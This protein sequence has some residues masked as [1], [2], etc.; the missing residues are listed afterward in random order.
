MSYRLQHFNLQMIFLTLPLAQ[1]KCTKI[2]CLTMFLGFLS[3]KYGPCT[4]QVLSIFYS[5][6][7]HAAKETVSL[8]GSGCLLL[9]CTRPSRLGQSKGGCT[10]TLQQASA[11]RPRPQALESKLL[12]FCPSQPLL[13]STTPA[14][15]QHQHE[16]GARW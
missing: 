8:N 7:L 4:L 10:C 2:L 13:P 1:R 5:L 15:C 14:G 16:P 12:C 9:H 11:L 6:L 3:G